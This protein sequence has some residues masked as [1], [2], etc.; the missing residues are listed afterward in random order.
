MSVKSYDTETVSSGWAA[1]AGAV[2]LKDLRAELRTR[3]ALNAMAIFA[4]TTLA[5]VS[6][7]LGPYALPPKALSAL[8]WVV[9]F[10]SAVASL[11]RVFLHE[12]EGRTAAALRLAAEPVHVYAG[13]LLFNVGLL[14][15]LDVLLVPLFLGLMAAPV[16][17]PGLLALVVLLG[18]L[19]LASACTIVAAIISKTGAKSALFGGLAF[20]VLLPL[21]LAAV[22]GTTRALEGVGLGAAWPELRLLLSFAVV[23]TTASLLLFELIWNE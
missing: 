12:E 9:I 14:G 18:S 4:V 5:V 3:Y 22:S 20:P 10:F 19:G 21:L 2:F 7:S 15:A 13:K 23:M 6:F 1:E 17:N 8:L 11:S 16:G